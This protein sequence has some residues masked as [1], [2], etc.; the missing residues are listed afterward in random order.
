VDYLSNIVHNVVVAPIQYAIKL[1]HLCIQSSNS[2]DQVSA[3]LVE[4]FLDPLIPDKLLLVRLR[5]DDLTII[6]MDLGL[7][8]SRHR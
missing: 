6:I 1:N 8:L 4:L 7:S 2:S 3:V 5:V